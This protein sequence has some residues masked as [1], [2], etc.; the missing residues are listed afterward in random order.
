MRLNVLKAEKTEAIEYDNEYE[1]VGAEN[2][3][4]RQRQRVRV[5][6]RVGGGGN[7]YTIG[8]VEV[9]LFESQL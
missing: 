9:T 1:Y 7:R 2:G 8:S 4:D 3:S 5:R 6:V